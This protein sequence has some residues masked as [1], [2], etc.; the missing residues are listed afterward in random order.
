[1][2]AKTQKNCQICQKEFLVIP[3]RGN[4][5]KYCGFPCRN[6]A[7]VLRGRIEVPCKLCARLFA[8]PK[9][10][11]TVYCSQICMGIDRRESLNGSKKCLRKVVFRRLKELKCS[12]CGYDG[13]PEILGIHH[14]D[15]NHDNNDLSNLAVVCANCHSLEHKR[16]IVHGGFSKLQTLETLFQ[17]GVD[18][19]A[20]QVALKT[21][22]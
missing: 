17:R 3:S 10:A 7:M 15:H 14:I 20:D 21:S 11:P 1:M 18:D 16:H 4:K 5:A 19:A 8:K 2:I 12:G 9:S 22:A 13:H 6:K